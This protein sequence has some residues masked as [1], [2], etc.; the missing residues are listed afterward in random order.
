LKDN[1][2]IPA[3]SST[4]LP[5]MKSQFHVF[6][7]NQLQGLFKYSEMIMNVSFRNSVLFSDHTLFDDMSAGQPSIV[8]KTG[9]HGGSGDP[10]G[11]RNAS[12]LVID[13]Q[14]S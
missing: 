6:V 13:V 11:W 12:P 8:D 14:K 10:V 2:T 4:L 7:I 9:L 3:S 5:V 1:L